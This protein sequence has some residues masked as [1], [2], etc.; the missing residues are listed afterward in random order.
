[1]LEPDHKTA[2]LFRD[3]ETNEFVVPDEL[4]SFEI[5]RT[6]FLEVAEFAMKWY[7]DKYLTKGR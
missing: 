5:V 3:T 2:G 6:P 4:D 7:S 1:M